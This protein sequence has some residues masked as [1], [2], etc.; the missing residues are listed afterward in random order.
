MS[1]SQRAT[2]GAD[3][4]EGAGAGANPPATGAFGGVVEAAEGDVD[5]YG[6][7]RP[8]CTSAASSAATEHEPPAAHPLGL[9][10]PG[11]A[12]RRQLVG[13]A[14]V[15]VPAPGRAA[16]EP[17]ASPAR[18]RSTSSSSP[19]SSLAAV[20]PPARSTPSWRRSAGS[21]APNVRRSSTRASMNTS[22]GIAEIQASIT[23][24]SSPV[25]HQHGAAAGEEPLDEARRVG[26]RGSG[27]ERPSDAPRHVVGRPRAAVVQQARRPSPHQS[28]HGVPVGQ[29]D[30]RARAGRAVRAGWSI[31]ASAACRRAQP[32]DHRRPRRR[33]RG[34][35][36]RRRARRSRAPP[37]RRRRSSTPMR[38]TRGRRRSAGR[39]PAAPSA[40]I[41]SATSGAWAA[42]APSDRAAPT[43][44][45]G[46]SASRAAATSD[47]ASASRRGGRGALDHRR[48]AP[49]STSVV[50]WPAHSTRRIERARD[51]TSRSPGLAERAARAAS[52]VEVTPVEAERGRGG[53]GGAIGAARAACAGRARAARLTD[54]RAEPGALRWHARRRPPAAPAAPRAG[55]HRW[56]RPRSARR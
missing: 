55:P 1:P 11:D 43:T 35:G 36:R 56:R 18:T 37:S 33:R 19:T 13:H 20:A 48:R 24:S 16:G 52:L 25:V 42:S 12:A 53:A 47:A 10:H 39:G 29:A 23:S 7:R 49:T 26:R 34:G 45:P 38:P 32:L 46:R 51:P 8:S 54:R 50:P 2:D 44:A 17:C 14:D 15:P 4:A 40:S 5:A 41:S 3:R 9:G 31:R 30:Q 22:P 6:R 27:R 21:N 28:V